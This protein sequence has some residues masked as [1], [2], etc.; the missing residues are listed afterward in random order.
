MLLLLLLKVLGRSHE[1]YLFVLRLALVEV[2]VGMRASL[3]SL[4]FLCRERDKW[5]RA[6]GD[7]E[8]HP[9]GIEF[10]R[11]ETERREDAAGAWGGAAEEPHSH[12]TEFRRL[13]TRRATGEG[14][15]SGSVITAMGI[16]EHLDSSFLLSILLFI[17]FFIKITLYIQHLNPT[18]YLYNLAS[19]VGN[20]V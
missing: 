8:P 13:E 12:G 17:C 7:G 5:R 15:N 4:R 16:Q 20:Q 14:G 19:Q 6:A 9:H 11:P 10:G 3:V 18:D 2:G 1:Y